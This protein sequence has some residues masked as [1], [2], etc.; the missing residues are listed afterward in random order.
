MVPGLGGA[1][2][3]GKEVSK[4]RRAQLPASALQAVRRADCGCGVSAPHSLRKSRPEAVEILFELADEAGEEIHLA[5]RTLHLAD[6]LD[7]GLVDQRARLAVHLAAMVDRNAELHS[8]R[9]G[10]EPGRYTREAYEST[11]DPPSS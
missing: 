6:F 2:D 3:V 9:L 1:L 11:A 5:G 8:D 4:R 7:Q 10:A